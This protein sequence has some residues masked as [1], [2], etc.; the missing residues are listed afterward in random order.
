MPD[1][2][3]AGQEIAKPHDGVAGERSQSEEVQPLELRPQGS[4]GFIE[5]PVSLERPPLDPQATEEAA[6]PSAGT[7]DP[8]STLTLVVSPEL[9][10][11]EAASAIPSELSVSENSPPPQVL[12]VSGPGHSPSATSSEGA[13][14]DLQIS[15]T[16]GNPSASS[17]PPRFALDSRSYELP[18]YPKSLSGEDDPAAKIFPKEWM[19]TS[20]SGD[21]VEPEPSPS[22]AGQP[23]PRV[24]V[25]VM[26]A[27]ARDII[28]EAI[29][30][31]IRR[32]TPLMHQAAKS[33]VQ[34]EFWWRDCQ[35]RAA[36]P[37]Y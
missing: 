14:L 9:N 3:D 32:V 16:L 25:L 15:A 5:R 7:V 36:S 11:P 13:Q 27:D 18:L 1:E 8:S 4:E 22:D 31:A 17:A 34:Q 28:N 23:L 37:R 24:M 30:E 2:K 19:R 6:T 33:E 20:S 10:P 29:E 35:A 26:L 12:G 21:P